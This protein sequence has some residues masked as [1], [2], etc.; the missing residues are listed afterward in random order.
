M[1]IRSASG[2]FGPRSTR[3]PTKIALRPTGGRRDFD[4]AL[5]Q[6]FRP[7]DLVAQL[8]EQALEFARAT[9][10]ISNDVE[11]ADLF[12]FVSP[13]RLAREDRLLAILWTGQLPDLAEALTL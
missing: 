9:M 6:D 3:S 1:A 13:E 8:A 10:D 2:V 12:A 5:A 7:F 4:G 11:G